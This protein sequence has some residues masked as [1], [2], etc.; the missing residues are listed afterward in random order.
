M[1]VTFEEWLKENPKYRSKGAIIPYRELPPIVL[2]P[3]VYE[4]WKEK[5]E[6]RGVYSDFHT[7]NLSQ[8]LIAI[9]G[10]G[11]SGEMGESIRRELK[12]RGVV[13]K[14]VGSGK[15]DKTLYRFFYDT[16]RIPQNMD[17]NDYLSENHT[18]F[19]TGTGV[20]FKLPPHHG[21]EGYTYSLYWNGWWFSPGLFVFDM[22]LNKY[23]FMNWINENP[24]EVKG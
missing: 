5:Y 2:S 3:I 13:T 4:L 22:D 15:I 21:R 17:I 10:G 12:E 1:I 20:K 14:S 8:L 19:A 23:S 24:L 18:G 9:Q 7:N 11:P 6:N 16:K